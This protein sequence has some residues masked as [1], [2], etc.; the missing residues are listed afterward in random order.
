MESSGHGLSLEKLGCLRPAL[1]HHLLHVVGAAATKA[2]HLRGAGFGST[3][4]ALETPSL[5][6]MSSRP[7]KIVPTCS[8]H[9]SLRDTLLRKS[10][11]DDTH[12]SVDMF[13]W[14]SL[15]YLLIQLGSLFRLSALEYL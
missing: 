14:L 1:H 4:G 7:S 10:F 9:G 8:C 11:A 2:L 3:A 6:V 13:R 15:M 5:P 12:M